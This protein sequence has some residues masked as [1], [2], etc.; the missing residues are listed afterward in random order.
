[1]DFLF[2]FLV[3]RFVSSDAKETI[4]GLILFPFISLFFI[5]AGF[6][7]YYAADWYT[8]SAAQPHVASAWYAYPW[9]WPGVELVERATHY[10]KDIHGL[11]SQPDPAGSFAIF[12][13]VSS[14][15]LTCVKAVFAAMI[16]TMI[17]F[18]PLHIIA[19]VLE[20]RHQN[21]SSKVKGA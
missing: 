4:I 17:V 9:N 19:V 10:L 7:M 21:S 14:W 1:M 16:N 8:T 15:L 6:G 11:E 12:S 18:L 3:G 5:G 2:G 20:M 13:L